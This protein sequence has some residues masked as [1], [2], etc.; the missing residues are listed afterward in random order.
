M[1]LLTG[2]CCKHM[3]MLRPDYSREPSHAHRRHSR[4][5]AQRSPPGSCCV[6][7]LAHTRPSA[8]A[9][10]LHQ[11]VYQTSGLA[12]LVLCCGADLMP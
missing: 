10:A 9:L 5:E 3:H 11:Y 1:Q 12:S 7:P 8:S 2:A 4:L 6:L